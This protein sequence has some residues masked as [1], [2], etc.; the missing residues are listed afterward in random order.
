M[1]RAG[2]NQTNFSQGVYSEDYSGNIDSE[3]VL[4]GLAEGENVIVLPEGGFARRPGTRLIQNYVANSKITVFDSDTRMIFEPTGNLRILIAGASQQNILSTGI[5]GTKVHEMKRVKIR[6]SLIIVHRSFAPKILTRDSGGT[7]SLTNWDYKDGPWETENF[8]NTFKIRPKAGFTLTDNGYTGT[9]N[10][11]AVNK[12]D[13]IRAWFDD[14]WVTQGRKIRLYTIGDANFQDEVGYATLT[15]NSVVVTEQEFSVTVDD[16]YPLLD[17]G[18]GSH[19][20]GWSLSAWYNNNF[21]ENVAIFQNRIYFFRDDWVWA[22]VAGDLDTFSPNLPVIDNSSWV[23]SAITGLSIEAAN[24]EDSNLQWAVEYQGLQLGYD[25]KISLL[26]GGSRSAAVTNSSVSIIKQNGQECTDIEPITGRYL[27]FVNETRDRIYRL[28]YEFILSAFLTE[29][30]TVNNRKLFRQGIRDIE[31]FSSPFKMLWVVLEDG[32]IA[33]GT[34]QDEEKKEIAWTKIVL[35]NNTQ[36]RYIVNRNEIPEALTSTGLLIQFGD[37]I[38]A[39]GVQKSTYQYTNS[40][41]YIQTILEDQREFIGDLGLTVSA[42]SINTGSLSTGQRYID[43]TNYENFIPD[44]GTQ[45]LENDG[46]ISQDFFASV[47]FRAVDLVQSQTSE[48]IS[49]KNIQRLFINLVDS[50]EFE[51][52]E[53]DVSIW[54]TTKFL[55]SSDLTI[56]GNLVTGVHE[57]TLN[58]SGKEN[59]VIQLRQTKALPLQVNSITYDVDIDQLK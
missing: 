13:N 17:E 52:K 5:T 34:V 44:Q 26:N 28:R 35:A 1:V 48:A 15:L 33:V 47:T 38:T 45:V 24:A 32:T 23:T 37:I 20:K 56:I 29:E 50:G 18:T 58:S 46:E 8:D 59:L 31:M 27:Y 55:A 11:L 51:V 30:V 42:G 53:K 2:I 7:W 14:D 9:G 19:N 6:D 54:K 41:P 39:K 22:T 36:I 21:P 16:D 57:Q 40:I 4:N 10:I 12:K 49:K 25:N 3:T 43:L